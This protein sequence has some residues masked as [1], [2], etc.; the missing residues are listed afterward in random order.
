MRKHHEKN[1]RIKRH[2]FAYLE[3]AERLSPST[4]DQAAAA[5]DQ[6]EVSTSYKDFATFHI[7]HA[8]KF[9]RD[10]A[11][12][13][14]PA[15]GKPLATA[16]I[17]SRLMAVKAL[18]KWLAGQPGYKSRINYPDAEYFNPSNND[19]RIAK[20]SRERPVASL[21]Q[22]KHVISS[23]PA[24]TDI[25]K[26]DRALIAFTILTGARDDAIASM[27][28]RHVD[29]ARR[30]VFQDARQVRTKNRKSFASTF[31]PIGD[32][33]EA[34]VTQWIAF[35]TG[36]RLYCPD[37]PIFPA[38]EVSSVKTGLFAPTG[39]SRRHWNSAAPIRR[40]FRRAFETGSL[41]YYNPHSFRNTLVI[42]AERSG[43]G[44]EEFKAWSQNLGHDKVLTT[45][46][47]YGPVP[48]DRQSEILHQLRFRSNSS[49]GRG[50]PSPETINWV[51]GFL[52]Q[53][54]G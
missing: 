31:F 23:M 34:V 48:R 5:I 50:N 52:S 2:Y 12:A 47:S 49:V 46:T 17:Y 8:R 53:K 43:L 39:L 28:L 11:N 37:D 40:I 18:F 32:E 51:V 36:E 30:T 10:L 15:T 42:L 44:P 24:E 9:K 25:E 14:N 41:P 4:V 33:I 38:T 13:I 21:D 35:L 45:F 6:F 26:R 20:A 27:S 1:E 19:G 3:E 16:T 29:V 7:E 54:A 22:I